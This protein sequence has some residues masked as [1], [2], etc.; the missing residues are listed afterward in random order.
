MQE[1]KINYDEL[2]IYKVNNMDGIYYYKNDIII[3]EDLKRFIKEKIL[4][5]INEK[6]LNEINEFDNLANS[7]FIISKKSDFIIRKI[8]DNEIILKSD[9]EEDKYCPL[10]VL[11]YNNIKKHLIEKTM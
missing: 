11:L 10:R 9:I 8:I 4:N 2:K 3:K 1:N 7:L 5:E 6:I